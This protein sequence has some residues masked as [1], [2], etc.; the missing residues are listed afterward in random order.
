MFQR[1]RTIRRHGR[2]P[3]CTGRT[4]PAA[5]LAAV[6][7]TV[8]ALGT[9]GTAQ[10]A[11][12]TA[13]VGSGDIV[14]GVVYKDAYYRG[15]AIELRGQRCSAQVP[16]QLVRTLPWN[17]NDKI[18][19]IQVSDSCDTMIYEHGFNV[20]ERFRVSSDLPILGPWN[21]RISSLAFIPK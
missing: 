20:G 9:A 15:G 18:S 4:G 13:V 17:W 12:A 2:S 3:G 1:I 6:A 11:P 10:A 14:M 19:S 7:S 21:D 16:A 8:L 5:V